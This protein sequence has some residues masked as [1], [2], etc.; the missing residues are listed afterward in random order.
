MN[1]VAVDCALPD[2]GAGGVLTVCK[3]LISSL[4]SCHQNKFEIIWIVRDDTSWWKELL[5]ESD[6]LILVGSKF[7]N[8]VY[9][10]LS[11]NRIFSRYFIPLLHYL[12]YF[13]NNI[14]KELE[15]LGV[16]LVHIPYQN[17][18]NTKLPYIYHIHDL[19]HIH[20]PKNFTFLERFHRNHIWKWRASGASVIIIEDERISKDLSNLWGLDSNKII[21]IITPPHL[22][23][24]SSKGN[25]NPLVT[26][27]DN[28]KI[29]FL[30]PAEFWAHKNH[31]NLVLAF[32]K[33]V[34]QYPTV[35]VHFTGTLNKHYQKI[36]KLVVKHNL[37]NNIVF[38]SQTSDS[39]LEQKYLEA[40]FVIIPSLYES[41][42]LPIFEAI[43]F[44]KKIIC[45]NLPQFIEQTNRKAIY[46]N[47]H[48]VEDMCQKLSTACA[49]ISIIEQK[50][51][52]DF[53]G[54]S[55]H[56]QKAIIQTYSFLNS[57]EKITNYPLLKEF[58]L[59]KF[60]K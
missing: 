50:I 39:E 20:L 16:N 40:D 43:Y 57:E 46:F 45:S 47:P 14:D 55:N 44:N 49:N 26:R 3:S 36:L 23:K 13:F 51:F 9:L 28:D 2:R 22:V 1:K 42:S 7:T 4:K 6:D 48:S 31:S 37:S 19:Q 52:F 38:L 11:S 32:S 21:T 10:K 12:N 15:A 17:G 60:F 25:T 35:K 30:Y 8:R 53:I 5:D 24:N 18:I 59:Q 27:K 34:K 54:L 33:L 58:S 56:F 41:L 29:I